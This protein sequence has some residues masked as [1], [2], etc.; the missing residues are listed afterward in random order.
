M[1]K[2]SRFKVIVKSLD[3][4]RTIKENLS[5]RAA[6]NYREA[7]Q[8]DSDLFHNAFII[9]S[10]GRTVSPIITSKKVKIGDNL[11]IVKNRSR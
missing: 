3:S 2:S 5:E 10:K 9:D 1:N 11:F 7:A 4:E 8:K 6:L